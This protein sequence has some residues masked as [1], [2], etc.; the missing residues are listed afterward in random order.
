M[1][2]VVIGAGP[3]GMAAAADLAGGGLD[4]V[5]VEG[6]V[7]GGQ[8]FEETT[9][10][11]P[12][13]V[14]TTGDDRAVALQEEVAARGVRFEFGE[15]VGLDLSGP[16]P[17]VATGAGRFE[18]RAVVVATGTRRR[19][20]PTEA[21]P[22]PHEMT[23]HCLPCDGPM[24]VGRRI[25]LVGT[26]APF[27]R[28]VALCRAITPDVCVVSESGEPRRDTDGLQVQAGTLVQVTG[29][30]G[31]LRL[32]VRDPE[33]ALHVVAAAA[34]VA[35]G[36]VEP[37]TGWLDAALLE[38]GGWLADRHGPALRVAGSVTHDLRHADPFTV[39]QDGR[40]VAA[41]LAASLV[42]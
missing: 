38:P 10:V 31:D 33:G 32:E 11:S 25:V 18:A 6:S 28:D 39:E 34:I 41:E 14:A 12:S 17:V 22:V 15:A 2:V 40:R 21:G 29:R 4:V 35:T 7:P 23:C 27:A 8:L 42:G 36:G 24:L 5:L 37:V 19:P 26:G 13:G 3:A 30:P 1:D 9:L 20:I 16:A